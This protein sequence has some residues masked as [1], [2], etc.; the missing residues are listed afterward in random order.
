M[1]S[2][3]TPLAARLQRRTGGSG[4]L[5]VV[6]GLPLVDGIF[7]ALVLAGGLDSA[8]GV[9]EVGLVVFGGSA[10][11]AVVLSELEGS[12]RDGARDVLTVGVPLVALAAVEAALAPTLGAVL[13]LSVFARFAGVVLLAV[14]AATASAR[15]GEYLPSPSTVVG[16]GLLASVRPGALLS[17][18]LVLTPDPALVGRAALAA[19]V[20]VAFALAAVALRDR[21]RAVLDGERFRFGSGLALAVLG[22]DVLG[23]L[24]GR[25]PLALAVLA[26]AAVLAFDPTAGDGESDPTPE[27][28][29]SSGERLPWQ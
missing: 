2:A 12:R 20:G 21:V 7:P 25:A 9:V 23:A 18:R 1:A 8:L 28:D 29:R 6:M 22:M 11:L 24:P 19:A 16:L 15:V 4:R 3:N 13:D 10:T 26:A 5:A 14:A 17:S 27:E